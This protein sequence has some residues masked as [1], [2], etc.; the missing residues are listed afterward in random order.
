MNFDELRQAEN[1]GKYDNIGVFP[2]ISMAIE[3][4]IAE[5]NAGESI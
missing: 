1:D 5:D 2:S 3:Q 4:Q